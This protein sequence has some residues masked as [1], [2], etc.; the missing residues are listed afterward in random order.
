[1]LTHP[2]LTE[3]RLHLPQEEIL[4]QE[5]IFTAIDIETTGLSAQKDAITEIAAIQYYQGVETHRFLTLIN[6]HKPIPKFIQRLTGITNDMVADAPSIDEVL[7]ALC[8]FVGEAPLIVG[9]NVQF[10]LRFINSKLET[11]GMPDHRACFDKKQ[12][13]CTKNLAKLALPGLES[14]KGTT[15]AGH[16]GILNPEAHRAAHDAQMAADIFFTLLEQIHQSG[17]TLHTVEDIRRYPGLPNR[18][19]C[20]GL[21]F[22]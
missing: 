15:L 1:M 12:A 21:P 17:Y 7:P 14:Y 8:Q 10:D 2:S 13:F 16:L 22:S 5:A 20:S 3:T 6:P 4:L 11:V 18:T 19:V 9:H